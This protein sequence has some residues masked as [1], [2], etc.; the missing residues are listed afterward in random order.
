[1]LV[2]SE[3]LVRKSLVCAMALLVLSSLTYCQVSEQQ[4]QRETKV[5]L[6]RLEPLQQSAFVRFFGLVALIDSAQNTDI[7]LL[8]TA[9]SDVIA[10]PT[11]RK[12]SNSSIEAWCHLAMLAYK[13][14][15]DKTGYVQGTAIAKLIFSDGFRMLDS[16]KGVDYESWANLCRMKDYEIQQYASLYGMGEQTASMSKELESWGMREASGTFWAQYQ[17]ELAGGICPTFI[18]PPPGGRTTRQ[19]PPS[20]DS[21]LFA[22]IAIPGENCLLRSDIPIYGTAGGTEFKRYI[23]EYGAGDRPTVWHLIEESDMSQN[24]FSYSRLPDLM[25]GDLD[26]RGNLGTWNVGLKNWEHL[27]WHP[28]SDTTDLNGVYTI[29]LTVYG[30]NGQTAEDHVTCEV[31]RAIAQCRA[32]IAVSADRKVTMRFPEQSLTAPFRVFSIR[33]I[34]SEIPPLPPKEKIVGEAYQIREPGERF[35][36]PIVLEMSCGAG[37]AHHSAL[38]I[39]GYDASRRSWE[40]LKTLRDDNAMVL[41]TELMALPSQKAYFA[42]LASTA[43]AVQSAEQK[44]GN[45]KRRRL[46]EHASISEKIL[47]KNDFETGLGE[48]SGRDGDDGA[49][50]A[51]LRGGGRDTNHYIEV[52][53]RGTQGNFASNVVTSPFDVRDYSLISFDYKVGKGTGIDFFVSVAGRWYEIGFTDSAKECR[54]KDVNIAYL[55]HIPNVVTDGFWHYAEVDLR[56]F[57]RRRTRN[58]VV[59]A[60]VLADWDIEGYMKLGFGGSPKGATVCFDNFTISRSWQPHSLPPVRKDALIVEDFE[61]DARSNYLNGNRTVFSSTG[62]PHCSA[63]LVDRNEGVGKGDKDRCLLLRY[64]VRQP[65][66][67]GGWLTSLEGA[68]LEGFSSISFEVTAPDSIPQCLVGL[69]GM[70]G[71]ESKVPLRPYLGEPRAGGWRTAIIP[72]V[73]FSSLIDFASLENFSISFEEK[74]RS[75]SGRVMVDNVKFNQEKNGRSVLQVDNFEG[76]MQHA[77]AL[78]FS[79]WDVVRGAAAIHA[80]RQSLVDGGGGGH[81]MRISYG[82]S[83]GLDLREAGFSYAGWT[84]GL[85]GIDLSSFDSL[86]FRVRGQRG[87]EEFNVYLDDGNKRWPTTATKYGSVGKDWN[88]MAIPLKEY[89]DHGIDVTHASELQ[90]VFEWKD[91]SGTLWVDDIAFVRGMNS[92]TITSSH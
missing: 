66:E 91:M 68:N 74:C 9:W 39:F 83:I 12:A 60:V 54:N 18:Q 40:L 61:G 23:V 25:Q 30:R 42:V 29:R 69:K 5:W 37:D 33:P 73:A 71:E 77:N 19:V 63:E 82:G 65:G 35:I 22:S 24:R 20:Q 84:T 89:I 17:N 48:W 49:S 6:E 90:F 53:K 26:L 92:M 32:G 34:T 31:G 15:L 56:E 58:T 76:P 4:M 45:A 52:S 36:K 85:G 46:P 1:M 51:R 64:E 57:L 38:G 55:G 16:V 43:G 59:D 41:R 2:I 3:K 86:Y 70:R 81:A 88:T 10:A 80:E 28:A 50:V 87:G 75:D 47:L 79:D 13:R 72:M 78:G 8:T 21:A 27:P 44:D 7:S 14:L 11:V 67:Y 62:V